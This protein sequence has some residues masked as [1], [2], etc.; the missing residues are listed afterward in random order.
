MVS[1][2]LVSTLVEHH[3]HIRQHSHRVFRVSSLITSKSRSV[4]SRFTFHRRPL[5]PATPEP[6]LTFWNHH[7]VFKNSSLSTRIIVLRLWP[8][9]TTVVVCRSRVFAVFTTFPLG[10][11]NGLISAASPT[12]V[13]VRT[14]KF[15]FLLRRATGQ[16]LPPPLSTNPE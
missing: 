12:A 6:Y 8:L 15:G 14:V 3:V 10:L 4:L 5:C 13:T 2:I 11:I 16:K 7:Q 1:K 9:T